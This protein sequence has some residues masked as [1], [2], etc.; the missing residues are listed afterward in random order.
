MPRSGFVSGGAM[1][2][3]GRRMSGWTFEACS[4]QAAAEMLAGRWAER[5][6]QS[7]EVGLR[8]RRSHERCYSRSS[9]GRPQPRMGSGAYR[10]AHR[11]RR[12]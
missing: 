9:S 1:R 12:V 8:W 11:G 10:L 6:E 7:A 4:D 3:I 2:T 5:R